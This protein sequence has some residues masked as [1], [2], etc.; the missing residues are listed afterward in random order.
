M[1]E[2]CDIIWMIEFEINHVINNYLLIKLFHCSNGNSNSTFAALN[3]HDTTDLKTLHPFKVQCHCPLS[4]CLITV[5]GN[6]VPE[7][8]QQ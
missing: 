8:N 6:G 3:L 2:T 7:V 5:G 4:I 1:T